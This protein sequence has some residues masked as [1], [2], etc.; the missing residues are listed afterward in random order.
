MTYSKSN[1]SNTFTV[2]G[3][4]YNLQVSSITF[5]CRSLLKISRIN[6]IE[7]NNDI[8][9]I[10][11][12]MNPGS[13]VP[14]SKNPNIPIYNLSQLNAQLLSS[15]LINLPLIPAIPD[16]VQYSV[17]E[18]MDNKHWN[19]VYIINLS[20][21]INSSSDKF[22][23]D[24]KI[25]KNNANST[26]ENIHSIFH[27]DFSELL[28]LSI[29]NDE[30]YKI[31]CWGVD[32]PKDLTLKAFLF[33]YDNQI[34]LKGLSKNNIKFANDIDYFYLNPKGKPSKVSQLLQII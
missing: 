26:L 5:P 34:N 19:T 30:I 3:K 2:S 4:F 12:M 16:N 9:A 22:Q 33:F 24:H 6:K 28:S 7:N 1:Y 31:A 10:F 17:M 13:A 21:L 32:Q 25:F 8:N 20:D 23:S 15:N 29:L 18:I 27:R 11:I 14:T